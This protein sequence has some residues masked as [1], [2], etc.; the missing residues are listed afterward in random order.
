[1]TVLTGTSDWEEHEV[2]D[3]MR[4]TGETHTPSYRLAEVSLLHAG[5]TQ[6]FS[7]MGF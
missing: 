1:M 2:T 7:D 6:V 5:D 4:E 3:M